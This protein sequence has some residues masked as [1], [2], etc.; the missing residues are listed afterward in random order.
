MGVL[1]LFLMLVVARLAAPAYRGGG[2]TAERIKGFGA[3]RV[4]DGVA[5]VGWLFDH[6]PAAASR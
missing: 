5:L 2:T 6:V 3:R 4:I 1:G